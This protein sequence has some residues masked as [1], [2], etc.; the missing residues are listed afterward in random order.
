MFLQ[1]LQFEDYGPL[2][3]QVKPFFLSKEVNFWRFSE[4][5]QL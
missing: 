2:S 3:K 5:S 1:T 4:M